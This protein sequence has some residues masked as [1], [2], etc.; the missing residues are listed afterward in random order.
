MSVVVVVVEGVALVSMMSSVEGRSTLMLGM[1]VK[2]DM[3]VW[4]KLMCRLDGEVGMFPPEW[5]CDK[6]QAV[7]LESEIGVV[8]LG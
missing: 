2:L 7:E 5:E 8:N 1:S 4:L 6:E 3:W